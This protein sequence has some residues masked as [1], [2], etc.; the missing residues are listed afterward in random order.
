MASNTYHHGDLK[1][2]LIEAGVEILA[3]EGVRGLSLRKVAKKAGVSH[4]APYAHFSDKQA[5]IAAISTEGHIRI[6]ETISKIVEQFPGDPLRQLVDTAWAYMQFG[7]DE[8]DLFRITFSGVV[9]QE[10]DYPALV[11]MTQKNFQVIR[12]MAARCQTAGILGPGA[13]DL[14][15]LTVWGMVHGLISLLQQG[16]VSSNLL[17]HNTPRQLLLFALN[18]IAQVPIDPRD[19]PPPIA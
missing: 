6:Y 18:Q 8:P 7:M 19:F 16:Q 5:L 10:Q 2:A 1:N 11:E 9:E 3:S 15:A 14:M 17:N 12:Q 4:S 13:S